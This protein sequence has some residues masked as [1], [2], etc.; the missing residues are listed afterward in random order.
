VA[1]EM[2]GLNHEQP[3]TS[4]LCE[5]MSA[6]SGE[7]I[8]PTDFDTEKL[9]EHL[10]FLVRVIDD[11]GTLV[12]ESRDLQELQREL[13]VPVS[14]NSETIDADW[15]NVSVSP[16]SFDR[17][18]ETVMVR[19][20]GLQVAAFPTLAD[21]KDHVEIQL[22][23]TE[24]DARQKSL[25]GEVRL[26]SLKHRK[27]LRQQVA[28][29][30]NLQAT[31]VRLSHLIGSSQLR[32]QL[33]DLILR[34]ALV[35]DRPRILDRSDFDARNTEAS[36]KISI[37]TQDVAVWLPKLGEQ[38]HEVRLKVE[39]A[40]SMWQEAIEDIQHQLQSLFP[41]D[42]LKTTPWSALKEYPRYLK[43]ILAR[44]EKL[45][46][47]GLPKDRKLNEPIVSFWV[48]YEQGQ[49]AQPDLVTTEKLE[50]L[51]WMIEEFRVSVFA[52]QLGTRI[53]VSQK[54]L[55]QVLDSIGR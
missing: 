16:E 41:E 43:A 24:L 32:E 2:L 17:I 40:P 7:L 19:R 27:L 30:P 21:C 39:S 11:D 54:R 47:G 28:H 49:Q 20:G 8:K 45:S 23:E 38:V 29:L 6:K 42:W 12:G 4:T 46:K 9:P 22:A 44:I 34:I 50:Q 3:F 13:A 55:Q 1:E 18:A 51:R 36:Q 10:R 35:E 53:S 5:L 37:A 25:G 31:S 33:A 52:Q 48:G 14:E 15:E 26:F